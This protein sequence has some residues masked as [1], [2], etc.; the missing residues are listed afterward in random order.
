MF[1]LPVNIFI[2]VNCSKFSAQVF[3]YVPKYVKK[4]PDTNMLMVCFSGEAKA[5]DVWQSVQDVLR[6][7]APGVPGGGAERLLPLVHHP[8]DDERALP[9]HPLH[10]LRAH[11]EVLESQRPLQPQGA[12]GERRAGRRSCRRRHHPPRRLQNAAQHAGVGRRRHAQRC[13]IGKSTLGKIKFMRSCSLTTYFHFFPGSYFLLKF[14][15]KNSMPDNKFN[16][17]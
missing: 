12:Y 2:I 6:V 1:T 3:H 9:E 11:A 14:E 16:I 7:R 15:R 4:V 10:D 5:A 17:F 13:Q 8:A